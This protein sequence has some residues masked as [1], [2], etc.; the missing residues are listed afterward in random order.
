MRILSARRL[1]R[2]HAN[3]Q[4]VRDVSLELQPGEVLA[5]MGVNGAG[6]STLLR[7]LATADAA[8]SGAIEWF[9]LGDRRSPLIRR[10][11]GVMLDTPAHFDGLTGEENAAFFGCQYGLGVR[12]ALDRLAPLMSWAG[13][14]EAA[15]RPVGQYSLGMRRRLG[16]VEAL[17]HAPDLLVLDEPTLALDDIGWHDLAARLRGVVGQGKAVVV[18]TNDLD[19]VTAVADRYLLLDGG[20]VIAEGRVTESVAETFRSTV[21]GRALAASA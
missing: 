19:L 17:L 20:R 6:K 10:R 12:E 7:V 4:G 14:A 3:R 16:L 18:A 5:L 9:G 15:D 21:A 13:L 2:V 8:A 11:L 1:S